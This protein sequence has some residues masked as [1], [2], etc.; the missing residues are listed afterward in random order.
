MDKLRKQAKLLVNA[1]Y[2]S[3]SQICSLAITSKA[4]FVVYLV[5]CTKTMG[6]NVPWG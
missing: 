1:E 3:G 5:F 6:D 2:N 4:A